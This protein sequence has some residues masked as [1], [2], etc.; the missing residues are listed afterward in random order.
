MYL[1]VG[2]FAEYF[3]EFLQVHVELLR[4]DDVP[5]I[6]YHLVRGPAYAPEHS[7][8]VHSDVI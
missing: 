3:Q 4:R 2:I 5:P 6:A 7:P 1:P 8:F